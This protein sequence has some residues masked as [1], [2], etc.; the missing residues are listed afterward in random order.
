MLRLISSFCFRWWKS[1]PRDSVLLHSWFPWIDHGHFAWCIGS[2]QL[3]VCSIG[4]GQQ[5][6]IR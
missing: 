5:R 4:Q 6:L 2:H 1:I 3:S